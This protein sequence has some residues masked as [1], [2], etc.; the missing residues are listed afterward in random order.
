MASW[1]HTFFLENPLQTI[2][3]S[4]TAYSGFTG[5]TGPGTSTQTIQ[6]WTYL[7]P[8]FPPNPD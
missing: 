6:S 3:G 8:P 7:L 1:S 5:G 2:I 4:D